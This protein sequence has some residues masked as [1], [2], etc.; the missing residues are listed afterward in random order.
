MTATTTRT[1]L[2]AALVI[3]DRPADLAALWAMTAHERVEAMWNGTLTLSQLGAWSSR[4]PEE[5]PLLGGEFAYIVM[6][7][8]EWDEA[9]DERTANVDRDDNVVRLPERTEHRAAA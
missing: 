5:V 8:P 7:T 1:P 6:R 2:P 4:R 9:V 3:N